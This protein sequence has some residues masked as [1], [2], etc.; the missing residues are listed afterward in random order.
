MNPILIA[1]IVGVL[2]L[3]C[4]GFMAVYVL[5]QS[6]G[7]ERIREISAAIFL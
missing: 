7:S 6:Q 4:A 3:V 1:V 2:G 5:R